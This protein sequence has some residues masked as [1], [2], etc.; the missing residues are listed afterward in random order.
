M[1][2]DEVANAFVAQYYRCF[3]QNREGMAPLYRDQS[4]LTFEGDGPK[5]GTQQIMDKLRTLPPVAHQVQSVEVQQ[6][7]APNAILVFCT[8][9]ILIEANK[10]LKFTQCFQLVAE[11]HN[12]Y[13]LHNDI[14]RFNYA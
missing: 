8:G 12:Q 7:V 1:S 5:R 4:S 10:P 6:S 9:S 13:Y 2:A 11:A 3:D 14:F